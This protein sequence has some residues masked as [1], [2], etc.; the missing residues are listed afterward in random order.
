MCVVANLSTD[1][2]ED[3]SCQ[4]GRTI[5]SSNNNTQYRA[6]PPAALPIKAALSRAAA[7][8]ACDV[9]ASPL[10]VHGHLTLSSTPRTASI[11]HQHETVRPGVGIKQQ[12]S[13][14]AKGCMMKSAKGATPLND[15]PT[16][17]ASP[18]FCSQL[19]KQL[20]GFSLANTYPLGDPASCTPEELRLG[21]RAPRAIA[22]LATKQPKKQGGEAV[23]VPFL[24]DS[25]SSHPT[26][27]AGALCGGSSSTGGAM[28]HGSQLASHPTAS[29]PKHAHHPGCAEDP[30]AEEI[31]PAPP[32]LRR[33][34]VASPGP[35]SIAGSISPPESPMSQ[36]ALDEMWWGSNSSMSCGSSVL[37]DGDR[38]AMQPLCVVNTCQDGG[39]GNT[40][41]LPV[42]VETLWTGGVHVC[43]DGVAVPQ[44]QQGCDGAHLIA[45]AT[46]DPRRCPPQGPLRSRQLLVLLEQRWVG[47]DPAPV[48]VR[49]G[50]ARHHGGGAS[51]SSSSSDGARRIRR[52]ASLRAHNVPT[53]ARL[54]PYV[55]G[56]G[57]VG[58]DEEDVELLPMSD[59]LQHGSQPIGIG[60]VLRGR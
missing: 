45:W 54:L 20:S 58:G 14:I 56:G 15:P 55:G 49:G 22:R 13:S 23:V 39:D 26:A 11:M 33:I 21:P 37:S 30:H 60:G 29:H 38:S 24:G 48:M 6:A 53:T 1:V 3:D 57:Q 4:P 25:C 44:Q 50:V 51:S 2:D 31:V 9:G 36:E 12:Q 41:D 59:V 16:V 17:D 47:R 43:R 27:G 19:T 34:A 7:N 52:T 46:W 5:M 35:S 32:V 8:A 10:D 42:L 28:L 40:V 18:S